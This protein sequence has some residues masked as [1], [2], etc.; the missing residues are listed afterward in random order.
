MLERVGGNKGNNSKGRGNE[1]QEGRHAACFVILLRT[2]KRENTKT[3][4]L[5]KL[6]IGGGGVHENVGAS[7]NKCTS[8]CSLSLS[9]F[10]RNR[11]SYGV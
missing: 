6:D 2:L 7:E 11:H 10:H 3:P 1:V 5:N 9:G 4:Y 8:F